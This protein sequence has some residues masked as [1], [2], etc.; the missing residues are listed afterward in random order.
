MFDPVSGTTV[1][2]GEAQ[3]EATAS[4]VKVDIL[5]TLL[6]QSQHAGGSISS[7]ERSLASDMIRDSDNDAATDL[8]DTVGRASGLD[9]VNCELG[10]NSTQGGDEGYWGLTT[11]TVSDQLR[12]LDELVSPSSPLTEENRAYVL[13]LMGS[14]ESD[15]TWGVSAAGATELKD[16]WLDRSDGSWIVNSIGVIPTPDGSEHLVAVQSHGWDDMDVGV[17]SVE[18]LA[19]AAGSVEV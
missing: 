13:S 8:W 11:T 5:V 19:V 6:L 10:L 16:G 12:L 7:S 15:Q 3:P 18:R 4:I 17:S 9:E 1:T 2:W 14:V